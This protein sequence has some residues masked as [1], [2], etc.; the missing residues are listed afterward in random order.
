MEKRFPCSLFVSL[1]LAFFFLF[2]TNSSDALEVGF[3][4]KSCPD[5]EKIVRKTVLSYYKDDPTITAPLLRLHFHDCFVEGC[6]GSVLIN[7]TTTNVAEKDAKPNLS[8]DGF[9]VIDKAKAELEAKCPGVVSCADIVALAARDAVSLATYVVRSGKWS[10]NYNMY[11]VETGR[12]DGRVST[13]SDAINNLPSSFWG[14]YQLKRSFASKGL[15]LK[16]LAVLSAAHTIGNS[17]CNS[18]AKRLY[19]YTGKGDMDPSLLASY[20]TTLK[21][22]CTPTDNTTVLEMVPGS[23]TTFDT[24]YFKLVKEKKG[25]FHSDQ[26]LLR[27]QVTKNYVFSHVTNSTG[28]FHDFGVSMVKMGR[29]KVLEGKNGEIRKNCAVIN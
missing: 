22:E 18:F 12:R 26:A 9:D 23:S 24:T 21:K 7:S 13:V 25:L 8:L 29:N 27:S 5:V 2:S 11:E 17:H 14:I 4:S 19:N 28:F 15:N 16:D 1:L 10:K 6:D 3:Y 20:A